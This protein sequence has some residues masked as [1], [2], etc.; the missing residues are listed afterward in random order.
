MAVGI[1]DK[2]KN[3]DGGGR[4]LVLKGGVAN[5]VHIR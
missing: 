5:I 2:G 3:N 4:R 1:E